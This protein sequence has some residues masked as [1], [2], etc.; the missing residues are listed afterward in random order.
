VSHEITTPSK[1]SPRHPSTRT[2][3][4]TKNGHGA[5]A[6]RPERTAQNLR[7]QESAFRKVGDVLRFTSA[8]GFPIRFRSLSEFMQIHLPLR[9]VVLAAIAVSSPATAQPQIGAD[10]DEAARILISRYATR[11]I[12]QD[13][14]L[15]MSRVPALRADWPTDLKLALALDTSSE[16]QLGLQVDSVKT[17][18][19][20]LSE[21]LKNELYVESWLRNRAAEMRDASLQRS[22][23]ML[24]VRWNE[25]AVARARGAIH[26][27]TRLRASLGETLAGFEQTF[28]VAVRNVLSKNPALVPALSGVKSESAALAASRNRLM[29]ALTD[30]EKRLAPQAR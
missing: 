8:G 19:P 17:H 30:A 9:V 29:T 4:N 24:E 2:T 23:E 5:E 21:R 3:N 14:E 26:A 27:R 22:T 13:A 18:L 7:R 15:D 12:L 28:R 11:T 6:C 1:H 20:I 25:S 10:L 16:Q